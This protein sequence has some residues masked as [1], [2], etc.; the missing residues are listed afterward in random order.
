MAQAV[1]LTGQSPRVL[2]PKAAIAY[3]DEEEAAQLN[4]SEMVERLTWPA[5]VSL[6]ISLLENATTY[7]HCH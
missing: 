2:E 5:C 7:L 6:L 3:K 1:S 4:N